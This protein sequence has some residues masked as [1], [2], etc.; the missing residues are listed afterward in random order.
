[1]VSVDEE[2]DR[3]GPILV[4]FTLTKFIAVNNKNKIHTVILINQHI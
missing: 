2:K 4:Y 3:S 1:M